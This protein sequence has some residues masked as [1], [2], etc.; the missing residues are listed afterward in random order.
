MPPFAEQTIQPHAAASTVARGALRWSEHPQTLVSRLIIEVRVQPLAP[1]NV[2]LLE[3]L[4]FL[5]PDLF[6]VTRFIRHPQENV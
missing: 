4:R 5:L 6:T 3:Y 2:E 1:H